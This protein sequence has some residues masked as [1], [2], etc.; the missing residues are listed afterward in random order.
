MDQPTVKVGFCPKQETAS[1][2]NRNASLRSIVVVDDDQRRRGRLSGL[3]HRTMAG[4]TA[5]LS[6]YLWALSTL[7]MGLGHIPAPS[8]EARDLGRALYGKRFADKALHHV[9][10]SESGTP[11]PQ[12]RRHGCHESA[13]M[14]VR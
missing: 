2:E 5:S 9:P 6:C 3:C 14:I 13:E 7:L 10:A 12:R 1:R 8:A 11:D 4:S